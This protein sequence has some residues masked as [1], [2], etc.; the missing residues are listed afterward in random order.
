[1]ATVIITEL[2]VLNCYQVAL[3][4]STVQVNTGLGL[5]AFKSF[6]RF[7]RLWLLTLTSLAFFVGPCGIMFK[8]LK[9]LWLVMRS[10]CCLSILYSWMQVKILSQIVYGSS[11]ACLDSMLPRVQVTIAW[12]W[13]FLHSNHLRDSKDC[14]SLL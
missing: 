4:W 10:H 1:M 7:W 11:V 9:P 2:K 14:N 12:A 6:R 13:I 8:E 3:I 5:F